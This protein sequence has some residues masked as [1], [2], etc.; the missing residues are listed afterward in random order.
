M[1]KSFTFKGSRINYKVTGTGS[2]VVLLHGFGEDSTIWDSQVEELEKV[3]KLTIPDLPGSGS[4]ALVAEGNVSMDTYAEAVNAL[5]QEEEITSCVLLGHSMGGYITLAFA[6]K[7]P[8]KLLAFGLVHSTAFSDTEEK[9]ATRRKGI[10]FMRD[11]GAHAF[12]KTSIPNLFAESFKKQHPEVI[13]D[14]IS[15]AAAFGDEAL[16]RY[17]EAMISR[18]DRTD[19][20]RNSQVPVLFVAGTEDNAAPLQ[21][22]LKQVHLPDAAHIQ[23]MEDTGH[24]SML[25]KPNDLKKYLKDFILS[26]SVLV[27]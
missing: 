5:L 20:L 27:D 21:D 19:V 17:Y 16:I 25:E 15:K 2:D 11:H 4:S 14:L 12:L 18:P 9:I 8:E 6:E 23:I 7:F 10:Q 13:N 22:V 3:C 26:E 1:N 24:M